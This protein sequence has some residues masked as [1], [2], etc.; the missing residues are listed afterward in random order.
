MAIAPSYF[1]MGD[2]F[3]NANREGV[4]RRSPNPR[5]VLGDIQQGI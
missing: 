1:C 5:D 4:N 3:F 2:R